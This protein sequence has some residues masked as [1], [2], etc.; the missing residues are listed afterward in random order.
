MKERE[1]LIQICKDAVVHHKK[2]NNRDSYV[3]QQSIASVYKGLTAGLNFRVV[4]EQ[5]N[6]EYC[7]DK[8]H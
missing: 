8:R 6:P 3:A 7:S 2:W 4:T 1:E 5:I